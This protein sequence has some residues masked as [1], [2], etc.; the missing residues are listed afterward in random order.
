M[1]ELLSRLWT[2][3][4][5][6]QPSTSHVLYHKAQCS[7]LRI[8]LYCVVYTVYLEDHVTEL[9]CRQFPR[10][11]RRHGDDVTSAIVRLENCIEEVSRWM[12]ANRLKLNVDE[13]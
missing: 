10:V 6:H 4:V 12:S 2:E 1:A 3:A 5:R 13:T 7:V 8:Y 11:R 9:T